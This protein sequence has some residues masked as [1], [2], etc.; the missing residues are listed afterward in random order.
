MYVG[1]ASHS[2]HEANNGVEKQRGD[3]SCAEGEEGWI[4]LKQSARIRV[5]LGVFGRLPVGNRYGAGR[6]AQ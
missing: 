3:L 6:Y 2:N 4:Y 5:G 1:Q